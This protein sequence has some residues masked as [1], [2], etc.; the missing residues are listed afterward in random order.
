MTIDDIRAYLETSPR[1]LEEIKKIMDYRNLRTEQAYYAKLLNEYRISQFSWDERVSKIV[2]DAGELEVSWWKENAKDLDKARRGKHNAALM[3][4][5]DMVNTGKAAGLPELH[6]GKMLSLVE[7]CNHQ[8]PVTRAAVTDSMFDM[9]T[10]IENAVIQK[11]P[12][13]N[14]GIK[15]IQRDM[16][17]FNRE[18]SVKQSMVRDED[19]RKDGGIEFDLATIFDIFFEE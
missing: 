13:Q 18:Y 12:E 15:E 2:R 5:R 8:D 16:I 11:E 14:E 3:A 1:L 9:L 19:R 7:I 10:T 6:D 4:F 17:R